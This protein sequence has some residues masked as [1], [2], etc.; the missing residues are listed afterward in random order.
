MKVTDSVLKSA[1]SG[2]G[3]PCNTREIFIKQSVAVVCNKKVISYTGSEHSFKTVYFKFRLVQFVNNDFYFILPF[4][5]TLN[6][7]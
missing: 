3:R 5:E 4:S 6:F 1:L 2:L 7:L